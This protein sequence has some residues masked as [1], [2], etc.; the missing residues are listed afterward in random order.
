MAVIKRTEEDHRLRKVSKECGM[1]HILIF[2]Q[3]LAHNMNVMKQTKEMQIRKFSP[4]LESDLLSGNEVLPS[5][6]W[7]VVPDI[8]RTS[9]EKFGDRIALV[10]SYHDPPTNMTYKQRNYVEMPEDVHEL[11]FVIFCFIRSILIELHLPR[12]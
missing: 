4:I 10:D 9:A 3:A 6:E 5:N 8:W 7:Q 1:E 12:H 2:K 11:P